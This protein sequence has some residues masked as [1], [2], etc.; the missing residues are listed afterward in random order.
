MDSLVAQEP[1]LFKVNCTGKKTTL[2]KK[3]PQIAEDNMVMPLCVKTS[4][5]GV[6][7]L[8]VHQLLLPFGRVAVPMTRGHRSITP[9]NRSKQ[10]LHHS[11]I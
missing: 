4:Q 1:E 7:N 10:F 8:V 11:M 3:V 9:F 5:E 2:F 6:K